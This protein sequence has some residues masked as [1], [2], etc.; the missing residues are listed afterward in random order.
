MFQVYIV[1]HTPPG[2]NERQRGHHN[3][4]HM[5]YS[6]YHNK[7]YL[8]IIRKYAGLIA[9]QFFGHLHSDTF[10]VIYEKNKGECAKNSY[11][12]S[13]VVG[14]AS[15]ALGRRPCALNNGGFPKP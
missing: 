5:A 11:V 9:G 14:A 12:Y 7:K 10:R 8:E 4:N 15:G 6:D 3:S 13:T 2:S 1:G